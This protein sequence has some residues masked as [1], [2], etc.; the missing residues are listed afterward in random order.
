[1]LVRFGKN[2][3]G[4]LVPVFTR[5]RLNGFISDH[6]WNYDYAEI[7]KINDTTYS[8]TVFGVLDWYFLDIKLYGQPK[9]IVGTFIVK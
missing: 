9:E 3:K 5:S 2:A 6:R 7:D 4:E 8:Y 1:M